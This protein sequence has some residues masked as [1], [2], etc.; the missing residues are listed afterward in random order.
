MLSAFP[1]VPFPQVCPG[2]RR[3]RDILVHHILATWPVTATGP[4]ALYEPALSTGITS[5]AVPA[6]LT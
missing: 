6:T 1:Q 3:R 5:V 4:T 2:Y